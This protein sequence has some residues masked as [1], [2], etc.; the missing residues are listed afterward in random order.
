MPL[1]VIWTVFGGL[2]GLLDVLRRRRT[3]GKQ[4]LVLSLVAG[5]GFGAL[6]GRFGGVPWRFA[7]TIGLAQGALAPESYRTLHGLIR[8]RFGPRR[9]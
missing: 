1:W 7:A 6:F 8:Q 3:G 9:G 2:M 5:V 4:Q